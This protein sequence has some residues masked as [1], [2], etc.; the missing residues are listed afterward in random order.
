MEDVVGVDCCM[1]LILSLGQLCN[2]KVTDN[3]IWQRKSEFKVEIKL[4]DTIMNICY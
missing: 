2:T 1:F 3:V 4:S